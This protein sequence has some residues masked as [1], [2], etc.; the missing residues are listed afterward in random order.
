MSKSNVTATP[1]P[2]DAPP[3]YTNTGAAT[4]PLPSRPRPPPLQTPTLEFLRTRHVILASASPRR[5]QLLAQ[6]GVSGA[7]LI[8]RASGHPEDLPKAGV[9]PFEYVLATATAKCLVAY[10]D[11][12]RDSAQRDPEL[13]IAADTVVVSWAGEVLEKPRSEREHIAMLRMLRD[14]GHGTHAGSADTFKAADGLIGPGMRGESAAAVG[15]TASTP[16]A[17]GVRGTALGTRTGGGWHRVFTAVA[18]V[19]PLAS[20]KAPGYAM[21]TVV[22]ETGV[23]FADDGELAAPGYCLAEVADIRVQ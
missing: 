12:V 19:A 10:E 3:S 16:A 4:I 13:V 15:A 20:A 1:R 23:K 8:V 6:L 18:A 21:E 17:T 22:E 14:A 5:R 7:N 9:T 2:I 11:A